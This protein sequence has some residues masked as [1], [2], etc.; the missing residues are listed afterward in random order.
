MIELK[1]GSGSFATDA[2]NFP[3]TKLTANEL[4]VDTGNFG[5]GI[6]GHF[7]DFVRYKAD[8]TYNCGDGFKG[9]FTKLR[10][11]VVNILENYS[12]LGILPYDVNF[13]L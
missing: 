13:E 3:S 9:R 10:G 1:I 4:L 12:A 5:S 7:A 11:E 8:K 6:F 2:K